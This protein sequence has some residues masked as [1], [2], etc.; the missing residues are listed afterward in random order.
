VSLKLLTGSALL[1]A[2]V[3]LPCGQIQNV[4]KAPDAKTITA[5][6]NAQA[7]GDARVKRECDPMRKRQVPFQ[8]ETSLGGAVAVRFVSGGGNL[9]LER[10]KNGEPIAKS[11]VNSLS[12]YINRVG[13]NLAMQS[14]R[15]TI[16]WTFGVMKSKDFNAVSAPGG[17]VFVSAGLLKQVENEAQLAGVLAHEIAHITE[18]HAIKA[19][20]GMLADKCSSAA[21]SE[22]NAVVAKAVLDSLDA[23]ELMN[24]ITSKLGVPGGFIDFDSAD[25]AKLL[26]PVVDGLTDVLVKGYSHDDEFEADRIAVDLLVSAGYNPHEYINFLHRIPE[27]GGLLTWHPDKEDRQKELRAYLMEQKAK[28]V[29]AGG[30]EFN[31]YPVVKLKDELKLVKK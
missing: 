14:A 26:G 12:R 15:P 4:V 23:P 21:Y 29:F 13:K 5:A 7:K 20:S 24:E 16:P 8:E 19:Y 6:A 31:K 17:Y 10:A 22:R 27:A 11:D 28:D 9:F 3:N 25:G 18:K 1:L 2:A 30:G